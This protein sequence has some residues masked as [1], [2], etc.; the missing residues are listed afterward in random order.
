V[1]ELLFAG[2]AG[3]LPCLFFAAVATLIVGGIIWAI[4]SAR[5]RREEY[6]R[7]AAELGCRYYPDDP[8]DLPARYAHFDLFS[9]GHG[10]KAANVLAGGLDGR[11]ALAFDY[12]YSTGSG[13]NETT[14]HFQVAVLEMPITAPALK[15]R[16]ESFLDTIASWVGH[17]DI[18]FESAEF[19]KRYH[20][21]CTERK[22]AYDIF[23]ARLIEYLLGCGTAPSIEMN[24]PLIMVYERPHGAE[25]VRRLITIA[26][27][28]V[29]SIP[30]YVLTERG[31][32]QPPGAN[33]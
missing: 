3:A 18:D 30:E 20:V 19:S 31:I 9:T 16:D 13:K 23:H 7:L 10:R 15:L 12:Q 26:Q 14:H 29:R 8:W 2:A 17:D 6:E 24:G 25:G 33:G 21:K 4:I 27:E 11:S 32:A 1:I 5:K 22:F 28:I